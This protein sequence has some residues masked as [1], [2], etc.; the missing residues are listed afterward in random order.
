MMKRA[1]LLGLVGLVACSSS[2]DDV[3]RADQ[4]IVG[5]LETPHDAWQSAVA[6]Y[7]NGYQFCAGDLIADEWVLTAGHCVNAYYE[8]TGGVDKVVIGRHSLSS[9]EGEERTIDHA[10]RHESFNWQTLEFDIG[11][12]H[13]SKKSTVA[14]SPIITAELASRIVDGAGVTVVGWGSTSEGSPTSDV[15]RQVTLPVMN[16]DQCASYPHYAGINSDQ[17]CAGYT[18]GGFDACQA[19][20]G[21]PLFM[22]IDGVTY[23]VGIVSWGIGCARPERPG[24]YTRVS[25]YLAWL[26][27][28]MSALR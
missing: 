27:S 20:S 18:T 10:Y 28:K 19:D 25:S 13:L 23:Q 5:G 22:S 12:L 15:L 16:H 21:S 6:I 2:Q 26:D 14:P 24:V 11:L 7:A 17:I 1:A 9:T 8:D 3:G 4:P